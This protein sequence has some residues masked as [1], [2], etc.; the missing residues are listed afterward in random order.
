MMTGHEN[1]GGDADGDA[2]WDDVC[3]G[4]GAEVEVEAA[5]VAFCAGGELSE[6]GRIEVWL[7]TDEEGVAVSERGNA[8]E[9]EEEIE[10]VV[11][12]VASVD[13]EV[14][15]SSVAACGLPTTPSRVVLGRRE[16]RGV[17][18]A[19]VASELGEFEAALV[20]FAAAREV[21][22]VGRGKVAGG[23]DV[24]QLI[25]LRDELEAIEERE[26]VAT[27]GFGGAGR[28]KASVETGTLLREEELSARRKMSS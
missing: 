21:E 28:G 6:V 26:V 16:L 15:A 5:V 4:G 19:E 10:S 1:I 17:A 11:E 13:E 22:L 7:V 24:D 23:V 25:E 9:V 20:I 18:G 8:E 12:L 14:G 3:A 2:D 27:T